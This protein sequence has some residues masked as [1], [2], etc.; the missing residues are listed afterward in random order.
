MFPERNP[1]LWTL[2]PS[3]CMCEAWTWWP[4]RRCSWPAMGFLFH[5]KLSR[6]CC[7]LTS[8]PRPVSP[9]HMAVWLNLGQILYR[10]ISNTFRVLKSDPSAAVKGTFLYRWWMKAQEMK[11][12]STPP[13]VV[14]WPLWGIVCPSCHGNC[15]CTSGRTAFLSLARICWRGAEAVAGLESGLHIHRLQTNQH[16]VQAA[17]AEV[18][19]ANKHQRLLE[20]SSW[21]FFSL[22]VDKSFCQINISALLMFCGCLRS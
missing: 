17:A 4:W 16:P 10:H 2:L 18:R 8:R 7:H 11:R 15:W 13:S 9:G 3:C 6:N 1:D 12:M 20:V 21:I 22:S 5:N 19:I 14:K